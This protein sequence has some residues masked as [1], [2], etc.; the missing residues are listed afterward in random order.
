MTVSQPNYISS[1]KS[2]TLTANTTTTLTL[3]PIIYTLSGTVRAGSATGAVLAGATVTINGMSTTTATNGAFSIAVIASGTYTYTVTKSGY[4]S[5]NDSVA[6]T[7]N[8][9]ISAS[10]TP[11]TY[12]LTGTVRSG[13]TSGALLSGTTVT[14]NGQTL[15]TNSSGVFSAAGLIAGTYPVSIT[16]Q[17]YVTCKAT[18]AVSANTPQTFSLTPQTVAK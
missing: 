10:L 14:I 1:S 7:Q 16:A 18:V 8:Q 12:T 9:T 11:V 5:A 3:T 17:G 15:T 13:S 4:V 2:L 6:M